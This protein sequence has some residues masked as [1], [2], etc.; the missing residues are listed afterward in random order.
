MSQHIEL[1][2]L[3]EVQ[4]E[5]HRTMTICNACR[6]CEGFCPV[7]PAMTRRREFNG[8][9]LDYLANLCHNCTACYHACQYKPP[10]VFD[11][12]VPKSL[13]AV[14]AESYERYAWPA[15]LARLFQHNG[16]VV[17]LTTAVALALVI[18]LTT[19]LVGGETL[20]AVHP[21]DERVY[22]SN[23]S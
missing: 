22:E 4:S 23:D 13:A 16:L 11:M 8:A 5:A 7:F 6:Y 2:E 12:N 17:S 3:S 1:T 9:S 10:H 20:F 15:G 21:I 19:M 14:R 18:V